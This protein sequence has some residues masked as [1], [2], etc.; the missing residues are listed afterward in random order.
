MYRHQ[1]FLPIHSVK[2]QGIPLRKHASAQ[3]MRFRCE[4]L[5]AATL[6]QQATDHLY[7]VRW[8]VTVLQ[9][10]NSSG[11]NKLKWGKDL[12]EKIF[13][14]A[15]NNWFVC[16]DSS[17][18]F[19]PG[20]LI[21]RQHKLPG[22]FFFLQILQT[23]KRERDK[24]ICSTRIKIDIA[25]SCWGWDSSAHLMLGAACDIQE[26]PEEGCCGQRVKPQREGQGLVCRKCDDLQTFHCQSIH[27][28]II[29][30]TQAAYKHWPK[31]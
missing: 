19:A 22:L 24:Q 4:G 20:C 27:Y 15:L 25:C 23:T 1:A 7:S 2:F 21:S 16:S 5:A 11:W 10:T 26:Q 31:Q 12:P 18:K 8:D 13:V 3:I 9:A 28:Y 6:L 14:S 17:L 29:I 30:Q